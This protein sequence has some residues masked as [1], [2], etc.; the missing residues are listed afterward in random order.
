MNHA[1]EATLVREHVSGEVRAQL[2]RR[3]M[4]I[5]EAA[6]RLGWTQTFMWRRAMGEVGF[7]VGEL[8]AVAQLL[9]S[10]IESF[11][12]ARLAGADVVQIG[13]GSRNLR[14]ST[15]ARAAA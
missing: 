14:F 11:F 4:S 10:P 7:E 6:R 1:D 8:A 12:P 13:A 15:P 3:K 9:G 2:G 5:S